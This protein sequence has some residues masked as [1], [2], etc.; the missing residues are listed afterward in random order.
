MKSVAIMPYKCKIIT[1]K[2]FIIVWNHKVVYQVL[3]NIWKYIRYIDYK[4]NI[5]GLHSYYIIKETSIDM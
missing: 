5:N 3:S 1:A 4:E 2:L